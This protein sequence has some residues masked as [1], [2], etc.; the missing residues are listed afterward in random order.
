MGRGG[1]GAQ[2]RD[3][4]GGGAV[5][6]GDRAVGQD[7]VALQIPAALAL[8]DLGPENQLHVAPLVL[9]GDED[10]VLPP[11]GVLA[12]DGPAGHQRLRA[13]RQPADCRGGQ[14]AAA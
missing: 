13:L 5:A 7:D 1:Y 8:E 6:A 11:L 10:C 3:H 9:D 2:G 12:G 4:Q 14:H